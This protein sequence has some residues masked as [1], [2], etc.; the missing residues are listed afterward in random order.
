MFGKKALPVGTIAMMLVIALAVMGLGFSIWNTTIYDAGVVTTGTFGAS[1]INTFTD[2]GANP[3]NPL[4]DPDD[5]PCT[6]PGCV[7]GAG[8][9]D[10][11]EA[12]P[13][14]DRSDKAIGACASW[15]VEAENHNTL[16]W[17][18]DNVYPG[19]YCTIWTQVISTGSVPMKV[20]SWA[21]VNSSQI[22]IGFVDGERLY[23]GDQI[24]PNSLYQVTM[25]VH[26]LDGASPNSV[27][28]GSSSYNLVQWNEWDDDFCGTLPQRP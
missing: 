16:H 11:I 10:P 6:L 24:E 5:V 7:F 22:Q 3:D 20:Q 18:L 1:W 21:H 9:A 28:S 12:G 27:Y 8:A 2:D 15:T 13:L 17:Q 25:Y 19:Y 23:C 14:A 4:K 26:V